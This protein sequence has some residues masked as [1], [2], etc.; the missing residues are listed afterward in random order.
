MPEAAA[1]S[2]NSAIFLNPSCRA[3]STFEN[4]RATSG[5]FDIELEVLVGY[6]T[7]CCCVAGE[8]SASKTRELEKRDLLVFEAV[9][10]VE[11]LS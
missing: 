7:R 11:I 5:N 3:P 9:K 10:A 6:S 4:R 1:S 8:A 2:S